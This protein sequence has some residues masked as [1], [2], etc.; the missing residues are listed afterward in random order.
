[1]GKGEKR[2]PYRKR[3]VHWIGGY[4]TILDD[5][6]PILIT[7]YIVGQLGVGLVHMYIQSVC[8]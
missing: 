1:M 6:L 2:C 8:M 4:P 7:W 5:L 3:L